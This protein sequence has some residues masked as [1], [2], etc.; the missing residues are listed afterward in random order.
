M[1]NLLLS[2]CAGDIPL[3]SAGGTVNV[4]GDGTVFQARAPT[5]LNQRRSD[6]MHSIPDSQEQSSTDVSLVCDKVSK[7]YASVYST[8]EVSAI[9]KTRD[10]L[11]ELYKARMEQR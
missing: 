6:Q 1:S 8:D 4:S 10:M 11:L 7:G 9:M 2:G 5:F 3:L